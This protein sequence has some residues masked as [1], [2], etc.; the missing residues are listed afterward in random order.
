MAK[1]ILV[2]NPG[3]TSTKV[4]V[5]EDENVLFEKTLRH[6]TEEI[7]QFDSIPAQ[8]D[9]RKDIINEFLA[10][11]NFD[12]KELA[13]V[14]GRGGLVKPIEGGTYNVN[15]A[16]EKDLT[17]GYAGQHA[18]NLGGL[19][20]KEIAT[21]L[22]IPAFIV[23]PTTVDELEPLARYTGNAE[24]KKTVIWHSLNQKAVGRR[25]AAEI[26]KKY[27][28]LTLIICHLGGGLSIG[29]HKNGKCIEVNNSLDGNGAFS[30]E[31]SGDLPSGAL[32]KMC[33]SGKYTEKEVYSKI[34]GK[35]G[36]NSYY[37]TN[38]A[39]KIEDDAIAGVEKAKEL[40]DA[41]SY[42]IAKEVGALSTVV[43]GKV[44]AIILTGGIAYSKMVVNEVAS[45]VDWIAPVKAYGGEDEMLALTQGVLRVLNGEEEAKVYV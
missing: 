21:P 28:D 43:K 17:D 18:S 12:V 26:G 1:K 13:A 6:Q 11:N 24:F 27:E 35:G 44:D 41:Y 40:Y 22:G 45:R 38:D 2:I 36:F 19:I 9:W 29:C 42:C 23:D 4:A 16:L 14:V 3:S 37:G 15:E 8:R 7:Q 25:Y 33:F 34:C 10:E 39:R 31:R 30:P 5:Y 20:A 32:V